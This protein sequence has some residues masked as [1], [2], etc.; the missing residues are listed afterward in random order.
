LFKHLLALAL[1]LIPLDVLACGLFFPTISASPTTMD[2]QRVLMV[3]KAN[4]VDVH[5]SV[6]ASTEKADFAWVLP[7]SDKPELALGSIETFTALETLTKPQIEIEP[8]G[9]GSPDDGS[10]FCNSSMGGV[11]AGADFSSGKSAAP[12]QV[13]SGN[14][15]D[16]EYDIVKADTV[17]E[18]ITWLEEDGYA[19][20]EGAEATLA[21]Y[22]AASMSFVWVKLAERSDLP[23]LTDLQPIILTVPR[24]VN[25]KLSFPLALS[26]SSA[27]GTMGTQIYTL[28]DKRY[29]VTNYASVDLQGVADRFWDLR[30]DFPTYENVIDTL[31]AESGGR[32]VITEFARDLRCMDF[33]EESLTDLMSED[34]YYLTRLS[35][36]TLPENLKDA[37]VTYAHD[38]PEVPHFVVAK[39]PADAQ[40]AGLP[41]AVMLV[42]LGLLGWG[43]RRP[44]TTIRKETA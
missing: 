22:V 15:G 10:G 6:R 23:S 19:I 25:S 40:D 9:S 5:V 26:A 35:A 8:E 41:V 4:T 28:A 3:W 43:Q 27:S 14:I 30:F 34:I 33:L 2:A 20:P 7:V 31:T 39:D 32:L 18:M 44:S 42:L 11:M 24:S 21:P 16:Y 36:R 12:V 37:T 38:A 29:R 1:V 17:E 13:E